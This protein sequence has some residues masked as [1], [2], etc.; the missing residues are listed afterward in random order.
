M[1]LLVTEIVGDLM[2]KGQARYCFYDMWFGASDGLRTFKRQCGFN[3]VLCHL[4]I[5]GR[6]AQVLV[7]TGGYPVL[8]SSQGGPGGSRFQSSGGQGK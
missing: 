1:Y 6:H 4:A 8:V 7:R 2:R 3:L 5:M